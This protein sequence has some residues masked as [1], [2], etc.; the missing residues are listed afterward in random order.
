M[1]RRQQ[2]TWWFRKIDNMKDDARMLGKTVARHET[3]IQDFQAKVPICDAVV[4][5]RVV[6]PMIGAQ[7]LEQGFERG[8]RHGD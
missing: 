6:N 3:A 2:E 7:D 4:I 5:L 1:I 8:K